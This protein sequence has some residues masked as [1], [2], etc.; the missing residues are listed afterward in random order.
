M[1]GKN[2]PKY[3]RYVKMNGVHKELISDVLRW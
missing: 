3:I 2:V 1:N